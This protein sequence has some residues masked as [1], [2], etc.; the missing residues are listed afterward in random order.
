MLLVRFVELRVATGTAILR[1]FLSFFYSQWTRVLCFL[2]FACCVLSQFSQIQLFATLWTI[3]HKA[4]LSMGFSRREYCGGL[5]YPPLGDLP[6]PGIKPPSLMS[7]ALGAEFFIT[8][9]TCEAP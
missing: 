2:K 4:P 5:P 8:G 3:A 7:P 9:T 6:N 1:N